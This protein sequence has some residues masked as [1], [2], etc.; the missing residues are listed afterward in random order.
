M[1]PSPALDS[2]MTPIVR[3]LLKQ[4]AGSAIRVVWSSLLLLALAGGGYWAGAKA[5]ESQGVAWLPWLGVG[6][7]ATV[8]FMIRPKMRRRSFRGSSSSGN[9]IVYHDEAEIDDGSWF[10]G[11]SDSGDSDGGDSGSDD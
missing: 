6:L 11:D 7:G 4:V 8:W 2:S 9:T 10:G 5:A 1:P 3:Q